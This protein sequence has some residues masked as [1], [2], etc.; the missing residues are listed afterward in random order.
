MSRV[1]FASCTGTTIEFDDFFIYGTAAALVFPHV[2]FPAEDPF[3]GLLLSF[4]TFAVGFIARPVGG[5]LWGH[6][7]DLVGRKAMLVA[8]LVLSTTGAS[9]L[10]FH[11]SSRMPVASLTV[12]VTC[13]RARAG[14]APGSGE[15]KV[16]RGASVSGAGGGLSGSE[17]GAGSVPQAPTPNASS[18]G[19]NLKL[20]RNIAMGRACT[21]ASRARARRGAA[22]QG[23]TQEKL[24][25]R[26]GSPW[27]S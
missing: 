19:R 8:S 7:G 12:P 10:S 23:A 1:A 24:S 18:R 15:R 13:T 16:T 20:I 25:A 21:R 17:L 27:P 5:V 4:S 26:V 11:D 22:A 14:R 6:F 2:F 9:A 3:I